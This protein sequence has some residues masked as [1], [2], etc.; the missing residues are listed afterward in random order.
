MYF[1]SE[2]CEKTKILPVIA[3]LIT[4]D[5]PKNLAVTE[6]IKVMLPNSMRGE[7]TDRVAETPNFSSKERWVTFTTKKG[8]KSIP[9]GQYDPASGKTGTWNVTATDVDIDIEEVSQAG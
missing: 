1:T 8:R 9:M 5:V 6:V 4:N 3:V 2:N 7:G